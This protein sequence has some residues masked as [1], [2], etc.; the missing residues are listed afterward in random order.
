MSEST[1]TRPGLRE[2]KKQRTKQDLV[3]AAVRLVLERGLENVTIEEIS[4]EAGYAPRTFFNYFPTKHSALIVEPGHGMDLLLEN[5][6]ERIDPDRLLDVLWVVLA[7]EVAAAP[8]EVT[9]IQARHELMHRYPE[10]V[11]QQLKA[12]ITAEQQLAERL[13][14]RSGTPL[15]RAEIAAALAVAVLRSAFQ[16]WVRA[17]DDR[18]FAWFLR[19]AIDTTRE[20]HRAN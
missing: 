16:Q 18:P 3:R 14:E 6:P 17:E 10:L 13:S 19:S 11:P 7:E 15:P 8:P 9:D 20:L 2:Q 5:L 4:A 12:F 1:R